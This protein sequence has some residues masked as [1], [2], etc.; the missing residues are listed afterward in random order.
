MPAIKTIIV[1]IDAHSPQLNPNNVCN[2][3]S[4]FFLFWQNKNAYG[5]GAV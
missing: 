1:V 4:S 3:T 5:V 2:I